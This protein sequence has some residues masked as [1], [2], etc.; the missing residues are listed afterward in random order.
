[1]ASLP[2]LS[3]SGPRRGA[4]A[5]GP[6][7]RTVLRDP[8]VNRAMLLFACTVAAVAVMGLTHN[9]TGVGGHWIGLDSEIYFGNPWHQSSFPLPVLISGAALVLAGGLWLMCARR[10]HRRSGS[11]ACALFGALLVFMAVD[12][13]ATVHEILE[14]R[15][16]VDWQL[17]YLPL[18]AVSGILVL[19]LIV[20]EYHRGVPTWWLLLG[21]GACW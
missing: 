10:E 17:L 16:G 7:A 21:G 18:I 11:L 20:R 12:E 3:R 4:S 5:S 9:L 19:G 1:M 14:A 6:S 13:V 2:R 15:S 8:L